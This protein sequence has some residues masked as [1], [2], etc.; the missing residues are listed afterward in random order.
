MSMWKFFAA[1]EGYAAAHDPKAAEKLSEAEK[2][3][4]ADWMGF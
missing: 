1:V 3:E 2:D 4:L